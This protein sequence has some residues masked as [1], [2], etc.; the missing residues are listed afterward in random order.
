MLG[1]AGFLSQIPSFLVTPFAGVLIDQK[2]R[3][4]ILIFTQSLSMLQAV[5]ISI[6]YYHGSLSI[7]AILIL[8]LFQ[9]I[10]AAI[11]QP[12]RQAI[13]I[14][15]VDKK[16][17]LGNAIA[18]NSSMIHSARLIGP[19]IAGILIATAGEGVCF[20]INVLS[21]IPMFFTLAAMTTTQKIS[22][23]KSDPVLLRLKEGMKYVYHHSSIKYFLILLSLISLTGLPY[24]ILLPVFTKTI[25]HAEAQTLGFLVGASGLGSL[26][27]AIYLASRKKL[28]H[29]GRLISIASF[30]FSI[31][32]MTFALSTTLPLSL[33][34]MFLIG[35]GMMIQFVASNTLMQMMVD[36]DKRGRVMS[37]Y[38]IAF[39]GMTPLGNLVAGAFAH[40]YGAPITLFFGGICC[41]L[42]ALWFSQ[43]LPTMKKSIQEHTKIDTLS[44]TI[45]NIN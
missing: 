39:M 36:N 20:L 42:S 32:I 14:D 25:F 5:I 34:S 4:H 19:S 18:L 12:T 16:E 40:R 26:T 35:F 43:K 22:T 23:V 21:F 38:T 1:L 6:L 9:G 31:G 7:H 44:L 15:M 2:N 11:D 27:G 8:A 3:K 13:V 24:V 30:I 45:P 33:I 41:F 17:D 29:Y 37:F 10:I 28:D